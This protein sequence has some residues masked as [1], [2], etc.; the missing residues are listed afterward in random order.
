MRSH[1]LLYLS[2]VIIHLL[3][4]MQMEQPLI[5]SD[6]LGYLGNARFLAGTAGLPNMGDSQFYHFGYSLLLMPAFWLF[7]A[8]IASYKVAIVVNALLI[9]ALYCPLYFVL[10]SFL[11]ADRRVAMAIALVCSFY[12]S[13]L[14]FPNF[15]WAESAFVL[16]YAT[17]LALFGRY[18]RTVRWRDALVFSVVAGFLYTIHPR[19]LPILVVIVAYLL[20]L[21]A[22]KSLPRSQAVLS[23][24]TIGLI[25]ALTRVVNEYL[26]A[27]GWADGAEFSAI[28]LA[29]RLL[30]G[31][32]FLLLAIRGLGQI[33][34]AFQASLG[35]ALLGVIAACWQIYRSAR[36][37]SSRRALADP[38]TGVSILLLTSAAGIFLASVTSTIYGIFG[39]EGIIRADYFIYGRYNEAAAVMFM[40]IALVQ[41]SQ[42]RLDHFRLARHA[43]V[44][45]T[46][47]VVLTWIVMLEINTAPTKYGVDGPWK[48]DAVNVAGIFPL[49]D[50]FGGFN[51]Y[52]VSLGAIVAY[53]MITASMRFSQRAGLVL[54]AL[55]FLAT[56]LYNNSY[57]LLPAIEASRSRLTFLEET[58]RL[59]VID[60]ISFDVAYYDVGML[61]GAQYQLPDTVF[62]RF[63]S[64]KGEEPESQVVISGQGWSQ[65]SRLSAQLVLPRE[66]KDFALWLLPGEVRSRLPFFAWQ[67]VTLGAR[68]RLGVRETGFHPWELF[69]ATLARWTDGTARLRVPVAPGNP[70]QLLELEAMVPGR[71]GAN[72]EVLANGV[73][74]WQDWLPA[75][76]WPES[77]TISLVDV[78]MSES[79]VIELNSDTSA[80]DAVVDAADE[81]RRLGVMVRGIRLKRL[82]NPGS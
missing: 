38:A 63:D 77:M 70:P 65:A 76:P 41:L 54:L 79:L 34:Y 72:L 19:A 29:S 48:V 30:P 24:A 33:L 12:P 66:D 78:P 69:D 75:H 32:Q 42:D 43:V 71:E 25:F 64:R 6:E 51:L 44:V 36:A 50:I 21:A 81:Q 5:F 62:H 27:I 61:N 47:L 15:A 14:L 35:L 74:L 22:M 56:S 80:S 49:V 3:V 20:V 23:V 31:S 8:P 46:A 7:A 28:T 55:L 37:E 17:S 39:P 11:H 82:D 59:G 57:Y 40:A 52:V 9:S 13:F 73:V 18:L 2:L 10:T 68:P 53:L 60:T 26:K 4:G 67:G 45:V 58:S 16:T 1:L